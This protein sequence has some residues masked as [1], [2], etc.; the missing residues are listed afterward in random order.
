[1]ANKWINTVRDL[2]EPRHPSLRLLLFVLAD[3]ANEGGE[4]WL[5]L[6][7]LA[8][9]CGLKERAVRR[10]LRLLEQGGF[11]RCEQRPGQ[12]SV[13]QLV[14]QPATPTPAT[15]DRG[16]TGDTPATRYRPTPATRYRG[17]GNPLP[18]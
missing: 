4:C 12:A 15:G 11:I 8:R 14:R 5:R 17:G 10:N 2:P 13:Y 6:S 18:P 3:A 1:M 16:K 9:R 7:V